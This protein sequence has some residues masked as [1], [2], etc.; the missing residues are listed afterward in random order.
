M[1]AQNDNYIK[2]A[3]KTIF[4]LN[5]D[6]MMQ[7]RCRDREEYYLDKRAMEKVMEEQ[8]AQLAE[9]ANEIA[10]LKAKLAELQK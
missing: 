5:S 2:E 10:M 1:L 7:K 4:E 3:S 8:K 9:Q 6:E